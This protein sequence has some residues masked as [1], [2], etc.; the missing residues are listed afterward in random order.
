M[1]RGQLALLL[2]QTLPDLLC[3]ACL[4]ERLRTTEARVRDTAQ[5][6]VL[7]HGWPLPFRQCHRCETWGRFVDPRW[8]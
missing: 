3:Y 2:Y 7:E 5:L 8:W 6:L 1:I 4:A